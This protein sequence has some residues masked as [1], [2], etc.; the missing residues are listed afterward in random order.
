MISLTKL[1]GLSNANLLCEKLSRGQ[2]IMWE[3]DTCINIFIGSINNNNNNNNN[4]IS[5]Y[6]YNINV[7][8]QLFAWL[9]GP[10]TGIYRSNSVV[11]TLILC[12]T[13]ANYEIGFLNIRFLQ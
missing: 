8:I 13:M 4:Q 11:T 3:V 2:K 6:V 9:L 10:N 12:I 7:S 5:I 1:P